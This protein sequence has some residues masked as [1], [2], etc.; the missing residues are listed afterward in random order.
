MLPSFDSFKYQKIES[1]IDCW[2]TLKY[3]VGKTYYP[4]NYL[5]TT[6]PTVS[7]CIMFVHFAFKTNN[8]YNYRLTN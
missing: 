5:Y 6:I 8:Q 3:D 4:R 2:C 1:K 7:F